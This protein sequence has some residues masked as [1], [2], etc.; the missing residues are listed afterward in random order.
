MSAPIAR[1]CADVRRDRPSRPRRRRR[2]SSCPARSALGF[3]R[4]AIIDL[5]DRRP[6]DRQRGRR[7]STSPATARSTTSASCAAELESRGHSFRSDSDTEVIAHLY[8]ERG[9]DCLERAAG[10]VRDRALGRAAPSGCCWP[11]TGSGSSRSTGRRSAGGM[12]YASEPGA[13][14]ASGLVDAAPDPRA[15]AEYLTLQYVP[16]PRT[17]FA[18]IHKLAPGERLVYER[19]ATRI[20]RYWQLDFSRPSGRREE[21]A[22]ER[23]DSL[24]GRGDP[25][26]ARR[27]RAARRLPLGGHRLE[28]RRQ[29]H[30]R[31][32]Q[33]REDLLDRLPRGGLQRGRAR[34]AGRGDLRHRARGPRARAGD[35]A[36][37]RRGR[38]PRRRAL[39][40]LLGDPD[41]AALADDQGAG[42]G[43]ALGRRRR[44]GVRRLPALPGRAAADR[45]EPARGGARL[46]AEERRALAAARRGP[47]GCA[48]AAAPA[49]HARSR[50]LRVDD[51][52]LHPGRA[53]TASARPSSSRAPATPARPGRRRWRCPTCRASTATSRS[54]PRPTCRATCC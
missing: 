48:R 5:R 3:R 23:L 28:P 34:P 20:E 7:A 11:A 50:A 42:D 1:R 46:L 18:G 44:R 6:A 39:R 47:S 40:R 45:L 14:L 4:L 32:E 9:V 19:G 15:L 31:G 30:G 52:P 2:A 8:E 33:R 38:A 49:R 24:L 36:A 27:R 29:L 16:P 26:S 10:D 41:A 37:D 13:I 35:R 53:R 22:L 25:R 51:V 12:L 17:G 21:E 43:G 54:T